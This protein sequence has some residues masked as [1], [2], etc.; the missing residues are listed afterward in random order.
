MNIKPLFDKILVKPIEAETV[1]AGGI[2]LS[3]AAKE[4]PAYAI[5]QALIARGVIGDYRAGDAQT[6]HILRFGFTST[7]KRSKWSS[8]SATKWFT[9]NM[10]A[11]KSNW[12]ASNT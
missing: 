12:K 7:A 11:T 1:S 4:K 2:I 10:P 5:V 6:P 9:A 3:G 8:K